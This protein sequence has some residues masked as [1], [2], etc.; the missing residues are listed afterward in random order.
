MTRL[1]SFL[2]VLGV[3]C[4]CFLTEGQCQ[5]TPFRTI[6]IPQKEYGYRNFETAVLSTQTEYD[7]FL[8]KTTKSRWNEREKFEA[9]LGEANV[10]FA[11]EILVLIR[12]GPVSGGTEVSLEAPIFKDGKVV[13]TIDHKMEGETK[14]LA[15]H[16]Y[17]IAIRK[18]V[19]GIVIKAKGKGT[20][21]LPLI[22]GAK[23]K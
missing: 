18:G 23:E 1:P 5:E 14:D 16:C 4:T 11:H 20:V 7:D 2:V 22:E 19:Q 21:E 15:Y 9:A 6:P 8:K 12:H 10:D 17:A 3:L 13:V